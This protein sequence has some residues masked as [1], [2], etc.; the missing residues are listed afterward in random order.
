M[1]REGTHIAGL[2]Q[3]AV[4]RLQELEDGQVGQGM[5]PTLPRYSD[6]MPWA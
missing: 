4:I 2:V 1:L 3:E 5:F 6:L